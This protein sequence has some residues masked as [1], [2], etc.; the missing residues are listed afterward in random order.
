MTLKQMLKFALFLLL[1]NVLGFFGNFL[2]TAG[3]L[4][5]KSANISRE[6]ARVLGLVYNGLLAL[7]LIPSPILILVYFKPVCIQMRK[8][9]WQVV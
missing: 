7:S 9:L 2:P 1:G 3:S 6:V 8:G 4:I 5:F